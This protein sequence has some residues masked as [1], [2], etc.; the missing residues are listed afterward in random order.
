MASEEADSTEVHAR[1]IRLLVQTVARNVKFHSS[2]LKADL[3]IARN[4]I[5]N[6]RNI[7]ILAFLIV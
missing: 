3:Y 4:V 1:C 6:T 2:R 7:K 5:K